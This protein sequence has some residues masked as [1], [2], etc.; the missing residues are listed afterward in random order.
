MFCSECAFDVKDLVSTGKIKYCPSCGYS[1]V[2]KEE[3]VEKQS[4]N[5][6]IKVIEKDNSID[7]EGEETLI[8]SIIKK[9]SLRKVSEKQM[10]HLKK[11]HTSGKLGRKKGGVN[12]KR[13]EKEEESEL[14]KEIEVKKEIKEE[15]KPIKSE[16]PRSNFVASSREMPSSLRQKTSSEPRTFFSLF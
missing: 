12:K 16:E 1:F 10:A 15:V 4:T 8:D 11:N 5:K 13:E 3:K 7:L 2:K 14:V 9:V 6:D